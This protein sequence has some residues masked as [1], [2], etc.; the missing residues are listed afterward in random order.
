MAKL[1]TQLALRKLLNDEDYL[2]NWLK[3]GYTKEDRARTKYRLD[4]DQLSLDKMEEILEKCGFTVAVEK[5][6]RTPTQ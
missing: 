1:T 5:Q 2:L 6:W 3:A 4:R